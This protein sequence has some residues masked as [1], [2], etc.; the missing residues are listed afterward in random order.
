MKSLDI[1]PE[2]KIARYNLANTLYKL[3]EFSN[4]IE[5]YLNLIDTSNNAIENS[6]L[7]YNLANA[8]MMSKEFEEALDAY[9]NAIKLDSSDKDAKFNIGNTFIKLKNYSDAIDQFFF[10]AGLFGY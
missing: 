7:Y 8:K 4:S 9:N 10:N 3:N 1:N 2:S 6:E 5:S